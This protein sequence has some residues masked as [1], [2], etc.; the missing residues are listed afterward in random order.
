MD[1]NKDPEKTHKLILDVS[2][3]LFFEKGY[4]Q[5]SLQDIINEL[6]GM[7]KGAI[8]HH[9]R[10][11][12]DIL[13][14]VVE[15]MCQENSNKMARLRDDTSL[16]G[17]QKLEKMF[18]DSLSNPK[19]KDM[20]TVTPNL[21]NNPKLLAYYLKLLTNSIV[22]DYIVPVIKQG[23]EDGSIQTD[24]PEEF[25]DLLMFLTDVWG[26]PAIFKM[27]DKQLINRLLLMKDMLK[28]F[29]VELINQEMIDFM[30]EYRR[31]TEKAET[32]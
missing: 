2:T 7:T 31:A 14:A 23:V 20:F 30:T 13:I 10:S 15:R 32:K 5:T 4:D 26:N 3:K 9:F 17:K 25:A 29:G 6:G 22:P 8:Y 11:K 16:T 19:Q 18:L 28:P 1:K 27:S 24:Y 12:E 21:L